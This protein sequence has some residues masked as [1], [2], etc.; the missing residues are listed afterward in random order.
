MSSAGPFY[1][2]AFADSRFQEEFESALK[3]WVDAPEHGEDSEWEAQDRDRAKLLSLPAVLQLRYDVTWEG[4]L[5]GHGTDEWTYDVQIHRTVE[6][7]HEIY[8][9]Q[10][11][12]TVHGARCIVAT[13]MSDQPDVLVLQSVAFHGPCASPSLQQGHTRVLIH[14]LLH[15]VY[16]RVP[17]I[18]EVQLNDQAK[19]LDGSQHLSTSSILKH[20][21]H[22]WYGYYFGFRPMDPVQKAWYRKNMVR[23]TQLQLLDAG[24]IWRILGDAQVLKR[25]PSQEQL[26]SI[27]TGYGFLRWLSRTWR[28]LAKDEVTE[29]EFLRALE[30]HPMRG[31]AYHLELRPLT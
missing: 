23:Y 29:D 15:T 24:A 19:T 20:G 10:R 30:F 27:G 3:S 16:H 17:D 1:T 26:Q 2:S 21:G 12:D 25:A 7:D 14:V 18:K 22:T 5:E 9:I 13:R 6:A 4:Y 11:Q 8:V 31:M 28:K